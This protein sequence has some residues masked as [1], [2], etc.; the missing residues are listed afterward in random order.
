M[1]LK[2]K[3]VRPLWVHVF[4]LEIGTVM[5]NKSP[6]SCASLHLQIIH[7]YLFL[8][9]TDIELFLNSLVCVILSFGQRL[10]KLN[11]LK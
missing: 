3:T 7:R 5:N 2:N 9:C 8:Y 6:I 4:I 11:C 1:Q 10:L